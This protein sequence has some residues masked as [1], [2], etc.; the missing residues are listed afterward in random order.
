MSRSSI[1]FIISIVLVFVILVSYTVIQQ[2]PSTFFGTEARSSFISFT[3][4]STELIENT[5]KA[6]INYNNFYKDLIGIYLDINKVKSWSVDSIKENS[7]IEEGQR[8]NINKY[9]TNKTIIEY[10]VLPIY[11]FRNKEKFGTTDTPITNKI[12]ELTYTFE[13]S[14]SGEYYNVDIIN[15]VV[16]DSTR[17]PY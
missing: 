13:Y 5:I 15:S 3:S 2:T 10:S 4:S 6:D 8:D 16:L 7:T 1:I 14:D 17:L 9:K 11:T 12:V